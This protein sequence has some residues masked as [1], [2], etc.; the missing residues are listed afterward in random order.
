[1]QFVLRCAFAV[2]VIELAVS[3]HTVAAPFVNLDFEQATIIPTQQPFINAAAAF[4]GWTARIGQTPV[5]NVAYDYWGIGEAVVAL[6]D[7]PSE[8]LGIPLLQG[9]FMPVLVHHSS[10]NL[11]ASLEQSGDIPN[12]SRSLQLI[13]EFH[14]Q[15]PDVTINGT[16]IPMSFFS[17]ISGSDSAVIYAGDIS[18]FA[19]STATLR[20]TSRNIEAFDDVRFSPTVVPEPAESWAILISFWGMQQMRLGRQLRSRRKGKWNDI[21][22]RSGENLV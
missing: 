12:E 16:P 20:F 5:N 13:C 1:M 22:H 6:F 19:G 8:T 3:S 17:E 15:A 18:A 9:Q 21:E 11:T 4:P 2:A 10:L 7:Q 14:R